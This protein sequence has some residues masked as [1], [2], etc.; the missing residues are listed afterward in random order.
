MGGFRE[1]NWVVQ[2]LPRKKCLSDKKYF[3]GHGKYPTF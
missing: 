1:K 2:K 3:L